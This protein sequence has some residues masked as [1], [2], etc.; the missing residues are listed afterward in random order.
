MKIHLV[1]AELIHAD[2]WTDMMK[3]I[4][5]F[6]YIREYAKGVA[7]DDLFCIR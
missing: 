1:V 2:R 4:G 3:L 5:A 7:I 6:E